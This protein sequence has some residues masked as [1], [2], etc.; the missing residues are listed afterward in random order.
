MEL[1]VPRGFAASGRS[2][3]RSVTE[4]YEL[5]VDEAK[6]LEEACRTA[7]LV[8]LIDAQLAV[9]GLVVAGSMGQPRPNPLLT[10]LRGHR[11]LLARL[12]AQLAIPDAEVPGVPAAPTSSRAIKAARARWGSRGA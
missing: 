7:D 8:A 4:R 11:Q 3:W 9:D 10:E 5:R 1:K 6:V 2:L 12:L